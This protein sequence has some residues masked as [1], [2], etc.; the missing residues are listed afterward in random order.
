MRRCPPTPQ[1]GASRKYPMNQDKNHIYYL[2]K[3]I[4]FP[5]CMLNVVLEKSQASGELRRGDMIVTYPV[6]NFLDLFLYR[7]KTGTLSEITDIIQKEEK[8]TLALKGVIRV[9]LEK[10]D[11]AQ[12][13][14]HTKFESVQPEDPEPFR[15]E[16]RKK[17]QELV[18]LINV[19]ESDKLIG[20]INYL[21]DLEQMTDF[22]SNYFIL[23]FR[24]RY[25]LYR[26]TDIARRTA[27]L[28]KFIDQVIVTIKN[29]RRN[30][31]T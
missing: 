22:I 24:R 30:S 3:K 27:M 29:K 5:Y 19:E 11:G 10:I 1:R 12:H 21:V 31:A 18:F 28:I 8:M 9:R 15:E 23:N 6:R 4:I 17:A 20:L 16:L 14:F 25:A 7:K 2:R 13:V 26:E